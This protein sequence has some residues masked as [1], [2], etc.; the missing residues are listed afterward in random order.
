VAVKEGR[1]AWRGDA[2]CTPAAALRS[3]PV[4]VAVDGGCAHGCCTDGR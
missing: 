4:E 2:C 1:E 3:E